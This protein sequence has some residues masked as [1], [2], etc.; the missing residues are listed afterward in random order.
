[1]VAAVLAAE[2]P[3]VQAVRL[4]QSGRGRA[5]RSCWLGSDAEVLAYT[6]VDLSTGLNALLPLVSPLLSGHSDTASS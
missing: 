2:L 6:D 5:L 3:E 1:V 4:T